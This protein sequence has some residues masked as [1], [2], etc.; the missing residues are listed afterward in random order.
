MFSIIHISTLYNL[1]LKR[2]YTLK[3]LQKLLK[4]FKK[5]KNKNYLLCLN[6][7]KICDEFQLIG[8]VVIVFNK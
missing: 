3:L 5:F 8:N 1:I 4:T 6:I 7:F 2:S